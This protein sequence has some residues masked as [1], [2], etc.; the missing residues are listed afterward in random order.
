MT[1][2]FINISFYILGFVCLTAANF[3][4]AWSLGLQTE[5]YALALVIA[6]PLVLWLEMYCYHNVFIASERA[7]LTT[8]EDLIE[9]YSFLF[10]NT[11]NDPETAQALFAF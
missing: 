11:A 7:V 2:F 8:C 10:R 5:A 9:L 4:G 6:S 1:G 3:Y